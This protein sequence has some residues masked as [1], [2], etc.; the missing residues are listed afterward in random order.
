MTLRA[1]IS[2]PEGKRRYVRRLF[3]TIAASG[4]LGILFFAVIAGIERLV[5]RWRVEESS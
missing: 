2:T 3:A 4:V 5:V 1:T